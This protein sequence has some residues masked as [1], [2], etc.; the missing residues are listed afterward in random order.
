MTKVDAV[1]G[2]RRLS[3][4]PVVDDDGKQVI[5]KDGQGHVFGAYWQASLPGGDTRIYE[6]VAQV[7]PVNGSQTGKLEYREVYQ[8]FN[9][10]GT[11]GHTFAFPVSE[12]RD[13]Q[14]IGRYSKVGNAPEE[15]LY[16][17][18]GMKFATAENILTQQKIL[19]KNKEKA[20]R[21]KRMRDP[22]EREER[23]TD[24]MAAA[25]SKV[26]GDVVTKTQKGAR[27]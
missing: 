17:L 7:N 15:D 1:I 4:S 22:E 2:G 21:M 13:N 25:M 11:L 18:K 12:S 5:S 27:V 10:D 16:I 24:K 26:V 6:G 9:P 23:M 19:A 20:E 8:R 3:L 14:T